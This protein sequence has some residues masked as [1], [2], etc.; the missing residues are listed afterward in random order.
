MADDHCDLLCLDLQQAEALRTARLAPRMAEAAAERARALG[1]PTRLTL[2]AALVRAEAGEL[3]VCDLA[4]IV[5]RSQQL[6]G[7]HLRVLRRAGLVNARREGKMVL[8]RLTDDVR[9]L[10]GA[11]LQATEVTR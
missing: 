7:H 10:L 6:V 3:C 2:A 5:E 11:V 8:Y 9:I 1:E 4:W